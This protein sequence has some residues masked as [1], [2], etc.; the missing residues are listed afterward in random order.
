MQAPGSE[1]TRISYLFEKYLD[2]RCSID[3]AREMVSVLEDSGN[4]ISIINEASN[5]WHML[6][7]GPNDDS[8]TIENQLIMNQ[9][10]DRLHHRI[11]LDEEENVRK[12][13][14]TKVFTLFSKVA[15]VLIL[16]LLVYSIYLNSRNAKTNSSTANHVVWQTVKTPAG[17]HTDFLL[18]DGTH[19]WLNSGSLFKYPVP[20]A[21][22]MR[23]VEMTGEAFFEVAKYA[24]HPF[25]VTAGKMNIEVTGTRFNVT[26]YIDEPFTELILESGSVRLFSGKYKEKLTITNIN[27]GELAILHNNQNRLSVSKADVT[28]Y[29]AWKD[30]VLIFRDD[31]MEEVVRKLN[32]WFNVEIILQ[33]PELKDYVYTATYR[34]ETL[35]QIL[36][37]L[38]ISAPIKYTFADRERLPDNS[39][40]KRKI[41]ITRRK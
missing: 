33:S 32:R 16:P 24:A 17:M 26:N 37:L 30:G 2:G 40:T 14:M 31:K 23:Q 1:L 6:S 34:D 7:N 22:D 41:V 18:P 36:E 4:D 15:A 13:S 21:T 9:I 25:L 28:K 35:P 38:K 3:E 39:Y 27:P 8:Y 12:F 20:F 29:T 10:L 5:R 19:V 11:R